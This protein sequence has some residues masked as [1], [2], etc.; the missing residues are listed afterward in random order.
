MS[1]EQPC[2]IQQGE[3]QSPAAGEEQPHA[4]V[5]AGVQLLEC[6]LAEKALGHPGGHQ[7]GHEPAV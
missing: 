4:P 6:S 2:V 1:Q 3:V 7:S 5:D